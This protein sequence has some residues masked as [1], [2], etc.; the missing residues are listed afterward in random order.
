MLN[1]NAKDNF[2]IAIVVKGVF[3][4]LMGYMNPRM[5]CDCENVHKKTNMFKH[6]FIKCI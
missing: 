6:T 5:V 2:C 4:S 1:V 3:P